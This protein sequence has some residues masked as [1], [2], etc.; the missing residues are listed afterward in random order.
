MLM[1][2]KLKK[3]NKLTHSRRDVAPLRTSSKS[4]CN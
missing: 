2:I 1:E 3:G 4:L